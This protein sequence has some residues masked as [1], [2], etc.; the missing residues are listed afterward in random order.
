MA[1]NKT[2]R[3]TLLLGLG[4]ALLTCAVI[5]DNTIGSGEKSTSGGLIEKRASL[6]GLGDGGVSH[7]GKAT[8]LVSEIVELRYFLAH[9]PEVRARYQKIA[10][11]YVES[12]ATFATVYSKGDDPAVVAKKYLTGLLVAPIK[13]G[14]V[15][16]SS[17]PNRDQGAV[18]LIANLN[19]A[20]NDSLA[21]EK[22]LLTLADAT[23][24]MAWKELTVTGD[25]DQRE[26]KASGQITLLM[27][28]QAE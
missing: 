13:I 2:H 14:D 6:V 12:I 24:G 11:P 20:S 26:L 28:E 4:A 17:A 18:M 9:A 1:I 27:V 21:F 19:F 5:Y 23:N 22:A 25:P 8:S 7:R 16:I 15:L 10:V 3:K